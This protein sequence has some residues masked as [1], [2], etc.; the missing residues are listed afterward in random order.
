MKRDE[1]EEKKKEEDD[2][3][4]AKKVIVSSRAKPH[5]IFQHQ[6]TQ[7]FVTDVIEEEPSKHEKQKQTGTM[8]VF[9]SSKDGAI[10]EIIQESSSTKDKKGQF[11]KKT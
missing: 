3:R 8:V 7:F 2:G 5:W 10:R 9:A 6:M 4:P 11:E 1:S